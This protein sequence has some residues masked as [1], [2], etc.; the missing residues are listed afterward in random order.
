M[1]HLKTILHPTDFSESSRY[2]LEVACALARDQAARLILLHVIPRP[3]VATG[4]V[5]ALKA[6]HTEEDLKA[7]REEMNGL[8]G[9]M[10]DQASW[11]QVEPLLKEGEV[12][13]VI[14][15]TVEET[16]C[17]LIVM[18]SHG[19]SRM[20]QL[21]LGS[22]AAAVTGLAGGRVVPVKAPPTRLPSLGVG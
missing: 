22:V 3:E 18:G 2:A 15:R 20:F 7:Y 12:A 10:R 19:K 5:P 1:I 6:Q 14:N 21:M 4:D 11:A 8:L 16:P 9:K 13:N 17:D